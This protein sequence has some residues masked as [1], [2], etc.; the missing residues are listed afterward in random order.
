MT[1]I[2][3]TI[4]IEDF[5]RR[6]E[7]GIGGVGNDPPRNIEEFK[8]FLRYIATVHGITAHIAV[9]DSDF[10]QQGS[11]LFSRAICAMHVALT[12]MLR[13]ALAFADELTEHAHQRD[14]RGSCEPPQRE[15]ADVDT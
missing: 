3:D 4:S 5:D 13:T 15:T 14:G 2:W 12:E 11:P 8:F 1:T 9:G 6:P 10:G 7:I